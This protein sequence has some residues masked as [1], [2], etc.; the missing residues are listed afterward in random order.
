MRETALASKKKLSK[1][2][3]D[4]FFQVFFQYNETFLVE[5]SYRFFFQIKVK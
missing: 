4:N 5:F 2:R 1:I 3:N